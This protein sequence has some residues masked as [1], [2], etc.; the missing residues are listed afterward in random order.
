MLKKSVAG[1]SGAGAAG[2]GALAALA[3]PSPAKAA[4]KYVAEAESRDRASSTNKGPEPL[5][6]LP[7]QQDSVLKR[8]RAKAKEVVNS[9]L[10]ETF[11]IIAIIV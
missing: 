8:C 6:L 7:E 11:V 10:F 9:N 5:Q 2:V 4:G 3:S 1:A